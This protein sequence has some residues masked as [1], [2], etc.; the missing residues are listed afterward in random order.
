L[1][2]AQRPEDVL[3]TLRAAA[4]QVGEGQ[5]QGKPETVARM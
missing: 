3:P 4:A 2:I 5:K 1:L